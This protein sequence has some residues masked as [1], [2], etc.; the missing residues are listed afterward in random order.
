MDTMLS[1]IQQAT[2]EMG[3]SVPTAIASNTAPDQVQQLALLN[4]V[5]KELQREYQWQGIT[6]EYQFNTPFYAYTGTATNGLTTLSGMSSVASL[7]TNFM[8]TG[9]GIPQNTYYVSDNGTDIVLSNAATA[10]ATGTYT[11]SQTKFVLPSTFDRLIDRTDWDKT[12]HWEML[13]PETPQQW[14]W[15]KSGFI[16]TGPRVRYRMLAQELQIWPPLGANHLLGLEYITSSWV[17]LAAGSQPTKAAFTLDTDTCVFN[18][19]LMV[20]GLKLKY[21]E[22][23]GL[24]T[25]ALYRDYKNQLDIAK[26]NDGG[27]PTLSMAPRISSILVGWNNLPDSGYGS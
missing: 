9:T 17:A 5:G 16:S 10:T 11:F 23:K 19:R 8:V 2:G 14:Q 3:L 13:G 26:A 18:D 4:A 12:Q 1:L 24:E 27:S 25:L 15:L 6:V 20:L 22:A 21:A 7:S